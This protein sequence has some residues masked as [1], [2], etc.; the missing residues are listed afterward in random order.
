MRGFAVAVYGDWPTD[1][2]EWRTNCARPAQ[3]ERKGAR[4]SSS[5][6]G[7]HCSIYH[8]SPNSLLCEASVFV[9]NP[10]LNQLVERLQPH[11]VFDLQKDHLT[12][13]A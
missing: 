3:G 12:I 1:H 9:G 11:A 4:C 5:I 10:N 7:S 13:G 6:T 2:R 8:L